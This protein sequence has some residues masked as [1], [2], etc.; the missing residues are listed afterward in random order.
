MGKKFIYNNITW[1]N[2]DY[3]DDNNLSGNCRDRYTAAFYRDAVH[4]IIY[5]QLNR[6]KT[7]IAVEFDFCT[8]ALHTGTRATR[9][10]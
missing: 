2:G 9:E 5:I 1:I 6:V 4:N 3:C 7:F 8:T 10:F